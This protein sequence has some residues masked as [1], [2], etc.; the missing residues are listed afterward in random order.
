[1]NIK[2]NDIMKTKIETL[3]SK[4]KEAN[5]ATSEGRQVVVESCR[6]LYNIIEDGLY[7]KY[8]DDAI[9]DAYTELIYGDFA[10][11]YMCEM[12]KEKFEVYATIYI[13]NVLPQ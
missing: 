3:R 10:E 1:V 7:E 4:I 13:N 5:T 11:P 8:G 12:K 9:L 2:T 6:K